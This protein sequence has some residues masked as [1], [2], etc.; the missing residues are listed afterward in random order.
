M[1]TLTIEILE[2]VSV[3][4]R[5]AAQQISRAHRALVAGERT[6]AEDAFRRS[7]DAMERAF[8]AMSEAV[9]SEAA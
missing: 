2:S 9:E 5:Y 8:D 4:Y 3:D 1:L 6:A 7:L